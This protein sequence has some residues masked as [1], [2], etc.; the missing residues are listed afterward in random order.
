MSWVFFDLNGTL[1]DVGAIAEALPQDVPD[2]AGA[3]A[4]AFDGLIEQALAMTVIG[5][6]PPFPDLLRASLARRLA[7]AGVPADD[8]TLDAALGRAARLPAF[9]EAAEALDILGGAG[10]RRA[11]VTNSATAAAERALRDAGLRDRLEAVVGSDGVGAYKPDARIYANALKR[12]GVR[13]ADATMV[14]AHWWDL[15]GA[16]AAGLRTAWV[17]RKERVL[18]ATLPEPDYRGADLREVAAAIADLG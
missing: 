17:A 2:R 14:A 13:P 5:R 12:L 10:L 15:L 4:G 11:V 3:A 16:G 1:L 8:A 18:L 6:Q 7:L 9:P